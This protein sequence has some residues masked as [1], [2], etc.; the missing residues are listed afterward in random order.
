MG[1]Y[2]GFARFC[3]GNSDGDGGCRDDCGGYDGGRELN[4]LGFEVVVAMAV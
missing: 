4:E 3:G 1:D 2:C